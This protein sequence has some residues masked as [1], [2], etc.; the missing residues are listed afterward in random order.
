MLSILC[1]R[2]TGG[3]H[4]LAK[5]RIPMIHRFMTSHAVAECAAL[6]RARFLLRGF[7]S[8]LLLMGD[9]ET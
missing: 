1:V 5:F 6:F 4:N 2:L 3:T 7:Q 9:C 8:A